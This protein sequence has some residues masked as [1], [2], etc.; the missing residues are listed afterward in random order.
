MSAPP[1]PSGCP[2][3]EKPY[4]GFNWVERCAVPPVQNAATREGRLIPPTLCCIS[5]VD[6]IQVGYAQVQIFVRLL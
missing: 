4:I 1:D 5:K 6:A 2:L 3:A